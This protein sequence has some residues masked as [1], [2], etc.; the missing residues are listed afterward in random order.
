[1]SKD[2]YA[3]IGKNEMQGWRKLEKIELL[4]I[5]RP[6]T[7]PK[8]N[9][10]VRWKAKLW[11]AENLRI[12]MELLRKGIGAPTPFLYSVYLHERVF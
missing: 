4:E 2:Q 10:K 8:I 7:R 11:K 12:F 5:A 1:M 3:Y 9:W 6:E